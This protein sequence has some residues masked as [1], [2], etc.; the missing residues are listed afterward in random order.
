LTGIE[1]QY[2]IF[3][4]NQESWNRDLPESFYLTAENRFTSF[5]SSQNQ[6]WILHK[7]RGNPPALVIQPDLNDSSG[8]YRIFPCFTE[9]TQTV[10][11]LGDFVQPPKLKDFLVNLVE[12][13]FSPLDKIRVTVIN[14][15]PDPAVICGMIKLK[16]Q[17]NR[18]RTIR[19]DLA[20]HLTLQAPGKR[21]SA[22]DHNGREILAGQL[23][24]THP[25]LFMSGSTQAGKGPFPCLSSE[26]IIIPEEELEIRWVSALGVSQGE[27][28]DLIDN[29]IQMNWAGEISRLKI[30]EQSHLEIITGDPDWN[31]AF[32][33]SQKEAAGYMSRHFSQGDSSLNSKHGL[34]PFEALYLLDVLT[35]IDPQAVNKILDRVLS[36]VRED[37]ILPERRCATFT[38]LPAVPL[39]GELVWQASKIAPVHHQKKFLLEKL[40]SLL[41][42]W[43]LPAYDQDGDGIPELAHPCQLNLVDFRPPDSIPEDELF[44]DFPFIESPGL[45][46]LLLND[47]T[48]LGELQTSLGQ[49]GT[50]DPAEIKRER[51]TNFLRESWDTNK[52]CFYNRDRDSHL[53]LPGRLISKDTGNGLHILRENMPH[54][55]RIGFLIR[56][57][58]MRGTIP[59][60]QIT[61]HGYDQIGNYRI[62]QIYPAQIRWLEKQGRAASE[63]IY[64]RLDYIA[65]KGL[66]IDLYLTI[67][68]PHTIQEDITMLLPLWGQDLDIQQ[69]DALINNTLTNQERFWSTFGIRTISDVDYSAIQLPWNILLGKGLLAHDKKSLAAELFSKLMKTILINLDDSGCFFSAYDAKTGIGRGIRNSLEGLIPIG[70]FLQVLGIQI[71]NEREIEIEGDHPFPWPVVLRYR[72]MV[73]HRDKGQ[74]RIDFPGEKSKIIRSPDKKHIRLF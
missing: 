26:L 1:A 7:N 69:A 53:T 67:Y 32:K 5:D 31:F 59:D 52:S 30:Q 39:A 73:I 49:N 68:S 58:S 25:A 6:G 20:G 64:S 37:G 72:G 46:T 41:N 57:E 63:C 15:V 55:T 14:W 44:G 66:A 60:F 50:I 29:L 70:F 17:S 47:L 3:V 48:R 35:P 8:H 16:N 2:T 38:S 9:G 65:V 4:M 24:D 61:L 56:G 13:S 45:G 40:E 19:L 11:F 34:S 54:P 27:S 22:R 36:A 33:L 42:H 18:T 12:Y 28:L 21:M 10:F 43:F 71:I 74:T 51:L 62:E 23:G